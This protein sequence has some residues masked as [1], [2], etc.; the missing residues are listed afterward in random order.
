MDSARHAEGVVVVIDVFRAISFACCAFGRGA[1]IIFAVS[2]LATAYD[3]KRRRPTY[4]LAG[5]RRGRPP[6]GFDLGNSPSELFNKEICGRTLIHTSSSGTKALTAATKA[7]VVLAGCFLNADA[8]VDHISSVRP[9]QV[10]LVCCEPGPPGDEV[11]EDSLCADYI[12][13]RLRGESVEYGPILDRLKVV[14]NGKLFFQRERPWR[15][16][17]DFWLCTD[18]NRYPILVKAEPVDQGVSLVRGVE[19]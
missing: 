2:E 16:A 9:P 15:P 3:L 7:S 8:V 19:V 13:R 11:D 17:S 12:L 6:E 10:S 14:E 1:K 5:E 4:L 18:L